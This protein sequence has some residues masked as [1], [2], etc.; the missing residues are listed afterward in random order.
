[1]WFLRTLRTLFTESKLG[2]ATSDTDERNPT[3]TMAIE[4]AW[5]TYV[6]IPNIAGIV[7]Y[8]TNAIALEMTLYPL[9]F[10]G[11]KLFR[12]ENEPWGL[13]GWQGR[14]EN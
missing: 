9:E 8:G 3:A 5:W 10:V 11:I 14:F 13:F 4:Y 7:G 2:Q 12:L 1:M 6:L